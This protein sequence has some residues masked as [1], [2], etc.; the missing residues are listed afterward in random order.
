MRREQPGAGRRGPPE[1]VLLI[2]LPASGK[3]SFARARLAAT[4]EHVSRD[5]LRHRGDP[6]RR[7]REQAVS[8]LRRGHSVVVD[9][10]NA[11]VAER[12]RWLALGRSYG[13]RV[14]GYHFEASAQDCLDRN[15][16]RPE[17]QRVPDV[18][19]HVV[20]ARFQPPAPAE[21]FD[22]LRRVRLLPDGGFEEGPAVSS[23][24]T[25]TTP[26]PAR[27]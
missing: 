2:G 19:I 23:P 10:T 8:S 21:G 6:A 15:R 18:A 1:L 11:T 3:T 4:H 13:A 12:A 7:Q 26:A 24:P 17:A 14:V 27:A 16:R 9:N 25:P 20:A 5:L 22:E